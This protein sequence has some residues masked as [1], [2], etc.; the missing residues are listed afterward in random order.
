MNLTKKQQEVVEQVKE[1]KEKYNCEVYLRYLYHTKMVHAIVLQKNK[2]SHF[3]VLSPLCTYKIASNMLSK[4]ILI[5][6]TVNN[7]KTCILNDKV[8]RVEH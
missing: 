4:N 8:L 3:D 6:T 7:N 5:E 1:L 2:E